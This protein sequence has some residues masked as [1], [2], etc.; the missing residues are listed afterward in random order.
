MRRKMTEVFI[1]NGERLTVDQ[2]AKKYN[3]KIT[4]LRS[5]M[6]RHPNTDP[7]L[8][9]YQKKSSYNRE[10]LFEQ[11]GDSL[12]LKNWQK[13][14]PNLSLQVIKRRLKDKIDLSSAP[15]R[16]TP[17]PN[18]EKK[19]PIYHQDTELK[20][21]IMSYRKKGLSDAEIFYKVTKGDFTYGKKF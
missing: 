21:R 3:L 11:N 9:V 4:T 17:K 20:N 10:K 2:A 1:I 12:T 6:K 16:R 5:R 14:Y 18:W 8:L 19:M 7:S 13:K 15:G